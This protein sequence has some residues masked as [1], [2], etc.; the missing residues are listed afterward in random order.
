M[1][2]GGPKIIN[3]G[4]VLCL[5]AHDA[6][7]YEGEPTNN[8]LYFKKPRIDASYSSYNAGYTAWGNNHPDAITVYNEAGSDISSF[9]NGGVNGGNWTVAPHAHWVYDND[10]KKPVV[11]FLTI[12]GFE[13]SWQAMSTAL[14]QT[15]NS[16]GMSAGDQYTISWLQKSDIEGDY[17]NPGIYGLNSGGGNGFWDGLPSSGNVDDIKQNSDELNKWVHKYRTYTVS[18]S[19][20]FAAGLSLYGYGHYSPYGTLRISDFQLE[21][22]SYATPMVRGV[23]ITTSYNG[24]RSAT[25]GWKDRTGNS[26]GGTLTNMDGTKTT[27]YRDREVIMPVSASYL[28]FDGTNDE[29]IFSQNSAINLS[30]NSPYTLEY[31]VSF[32]YLPTST[33]AATI[34]KGSFASSYGHLFIKNTNDANTQI[35]VYTDDDS[36]PELTVNY[37]ISTATWYH[38]VQTF[39]GDT[40]KLYVNGELEGS[41][42]GLTSTSNTSSLRLGSHN[43]AGYFLNGDLA[44][45]SIYNIALTDAQILSNYNA[46]KGRFL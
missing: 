46:T 10:L 6:K 22:K 20:N 37:L 4:L 33:F 27:H 1:I 40:A 26:T 11:Q 18:S 30:A 43:G 29:V 16:L 14:G 38:I 31:W 15:M 28:R 3:D 41:A 9:I 7:S 19:W 36:S 13:S 34:M 2:K 32:N 17:W 45:V 8:F 12:S 21:T 42:S 5:D 44:K 25:S 39:S 23:P 24:I 35:L